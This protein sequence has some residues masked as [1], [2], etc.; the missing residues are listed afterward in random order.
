MDETSPLIRNFMVVS[1]PGV[2]WLESFSEHHPPCFL[3]R[4]GA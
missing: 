4:V 3:N 2:L 1:L